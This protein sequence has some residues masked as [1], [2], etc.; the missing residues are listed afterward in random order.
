M[1]ISATCDIWNKKKVNIAIMTMMTTLRM[2]ACGL[3]SFVDYFNVKTCDMWRG[4]CDNK[5]GA[6]Q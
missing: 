5:E 4:K 3:H 6:L 1:R 2:Q